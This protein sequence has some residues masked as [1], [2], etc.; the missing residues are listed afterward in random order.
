MLEEFE[1]RSKKVVVVKKSKKVIVEPPVL[2]QDEDVVLV[3]R[4]ESYKASARE[5]RRAGIQVLE[6]VNGDSAP[7]TPQKNVKV[8]RLA[9]TPVLHNSPRQ[10][11]EES[12]VNTPTSRRTS[13]REIAETPYGRPKQLPNNE[14]KTPI[15]ATVQKV[16]KT[17]QR[18]YATGINFMVLKLD[19]D[20][21][22]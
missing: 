17:K 2:Q 21:G 14:T 9:L 15:K 10:H 13:P 8:K 3:R 4:S 12:Q 5:P 11:A 19:A 7:K 18:R 16:H 20:T 22:A 1:C 6:D